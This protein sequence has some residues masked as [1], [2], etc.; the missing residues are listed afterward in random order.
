M[1]LNNAMKKVYFILI[2]C[3]LFCLGACKDEKD[4]MG[5][6]GNLQLSV[7]MSDKISVATRAL[8]GEEQTALEQNCKVRIFNEKALVRK[9]Q[10]T[11]NVPASI[12]LASGNY[13]VRVTAGDSVAASFEKRF[14]EGKKEFAVSKG[15]DTTVEV[16]CGIA[17]TVVAFTWDE[18]LKEVFKGDYKVVVS[19]ATGELEYSSAQADAKGYFS[20]P[21]DNRKLKLKF[22]ATQ[23]SGKPYTV[24]KELDDTQPATLYNLTYKYSA[25][26]QGATGGASIAIE[27]NEEPLEEQETSV[28]IKQRPV[29]ICKNAENAEFDLAQPMYLETNAKEAYRLV[30]STS[31]PL[32]HAVL[33]NDKFSSYGLVNAFDMMQLKADEKAALE[34]AGISFKT[35][36]AVLEKG[37][38]WEILF[39]EAIIGKMTGQEGETTTL[40][41]ATD[42]NGKQRIVKWRIIA[43]NATVVTTE[44]IPYEIWASKATLHGKVAG[45]LAATPKF[46]YRVKSSGASWTTVDADLAESTFSKEITGLTPGTIYEY[47]AMDGTQASSV[48]CEFT[49]EAAFQPENAGF[50][51]ISGSKPTLI[52]GDKQQMWWDTGNHG[53]STAN[54]PDVTVADKTVKHSGNQ[55]VLLSSKVAGVPGLFTKFAAGNLFV[56]DYL[57]T[58]GADGVLGWGRPCYSRPTALR[59][60]VR[61]EPGTVNQGSGKKIAKDETDK[62]IIY[63]AVGDWSGQEDKGQKWPFIV[64]TKDASSLFS[65]QKGTYSGDGIIGYGE[66]TFDEAYKDGEN[67]KELTIELDY[68]SFGGYQRKPTS[69]I[70]VASSSK[71]GDYFEGSDASKM[72]LDDIELIYE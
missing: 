36:S 29:I 44:P 43:S 11:A 42:R 64:K 71:F 40:L 10:G 14:F 50:E 34:A 17:N 30:I 70:I 23:I 32:E 55:S 31:S 67:M 28:S 25:T 48:T 26:E 2:T 24:E 65:A 38:T 33:Q 18:S 63:I 13:S 46:Q 6:Q 57:R 3:F 15:E 49:T 59:V 1:F 62:G 21:A 12:P 39:S 22:S 68:D 52:Y 61:Y 20:L 27:V 16:Q 9:Y 60:W 35:P 7:A 53:S 37:G 47:Q 41:T 69:I 19:S 58:D 8:S 66:K 5:N 56:G 51:F 54:G 72:W 4:L 45:T